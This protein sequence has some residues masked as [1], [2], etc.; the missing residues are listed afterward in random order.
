MF[1]DY[2]KYLKTSLKVYI[3]VLFAE[4]ESLFKFAKKLARK[5]F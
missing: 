1:K 4:E 2:N 3:F 5:L